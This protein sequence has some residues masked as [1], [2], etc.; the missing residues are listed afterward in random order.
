[1]SW[2][3]GTTRERSERVAP[4]ANSTAAERVIS[5]RVAAG[6]PTVTS[7]ERYHLA[8]WPGIEFPRRRCSRTAPRRL[9]LLGDLPGP[10]GRHPRRLTG[11]LGVDGRPGG[12][13]EAGRPVPLVELEH[14]FERLRPHGRPR[15]PS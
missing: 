14:R 7:R 9:L 11:H 4:A 10:A 1:M 5:R 12:V 13:L 15:V 3:W 6:A 8:Q 2:P